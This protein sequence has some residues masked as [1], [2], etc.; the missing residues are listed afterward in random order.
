[1]ATTKA[2]ELSQFSS[3]LILDEANDIATLGIQ[4]GVDQLGVGTIT[5]TTVLDATGTIN[6]NIFSIN[7]P[8]GENPNFIMKGAG[9]QTFRF[10]NTNLTGSTR[11]SWKMADRVDTDWR[12]IMYTDLL[13]NGDESFTIQGKTSGNVFTAYDGK[14]GIGTAAPSTKFNVVANTTYDAV[15]IT[16]AGTGNALVVEDSTNPDSTPTVIDAN[17]RLIVG[18]SSA[19]TNL[20]TTTPQAQVHTNIASSGWS[21]IT[22]FNWSSSNQ[23]AGVNFAKSRSGT[24]GTQTIVQSGDN[25]GSMIFYGDDGTN[26]VPA[27]LITASVD[28]TPGANDMPGRLTFATSSDGTKNPEER[29]RI[30]SGGRVGIGVIPY[31]G[32]KLVIG[33]NATDSATDSVINL[34]AIQPSATVKWNGFAT[35]PSLAAGS[36]TLTALR[37][38]DANFN[39]LGA[40]AS[41]TNQFGFIANSTLTAAS[42]NFGFYSNIPITSGKACW[43]FFAAGTAPNYFGGDVT[44]VGN[45]IVTDP[46]VQQSDIGTGANEIPT[47][48]MLGGMAYQDPAV[49]NIDGGSAILSDVT[50]TNIYQDTDISNVKPSLLLDFANSKQLDPRVTFSRA[51]TA[52]YY[53]GKTVT[54]A[55]EN[56]FT[57]SQ[58][59]SSSNWGKTQTTVFQNV[60]LA[61][62]GTITAAALLD[63]TTNAV[64]YISNAVAVVSSAVAYTYS[65][66][67]KNNGLGFTAVNIFDGNSNVTWFNL[68]NVTVGTNAAGNTSSIV[69]A[70]N[71]WRRISVTRTVTAGNL[72]V[73][74]Y[75]STAD[76]LVTYAGDGASGLYIWGAQL[77]QRSAVSSYTATTTQPITNYIPVLQ[78]APAG[79]PRFE[80]NP[81]TGES[82]GLEIEEQRTNVL[83]VSS[84]FSSGTWNKQRLSVI[85]NTMVAPDGTLTADKLVEDTTENNTHLIV[86]NMT[87]SATTYTYSAYAKAGERTK[88][89]LL[90][91]SD[92]GGSFVDAD[93][94]AGTVGTVQVYSSGFTGISSAITPVGNGVYRVAYTFTAPAALAYVQISLRNNGGATIY[95]GDGYSGLYVWGA[96]LEVG[97]FATSYMTSGSTRA[98]DLTSMTGTDF[99]SWYNPVEG[100]LYAEWQKYGSVNFQTIFSVNDASSAGTNLIQ[101]SH[102]SGAPNNSHRFDVNAAGASQVLTVLASPVALNTW[103]KSVGAYAFNNFASA[104]NGGSAIVDTFGV[105]PVVTQSTIGMSGAGFVQLNGT[106][107]RIAYYP[108]R[109]SNAEL[110]EMTAI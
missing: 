25:I 50:G 23:A 85:S 64:H 70:G 4:V 57:Q 1:M 33:G 65:V 95:T 49:V 12:W 34:Q 30:D 97:G 58:N 17:G 47:N 53:D 80:H 37:H 45:L 35:Y 87:L 93:L 91:T 103:Y 67:V 88:I 2:L 20:D 102:G 75:T 29:M 110:Q 13:E 41:I 3:G 9:E 63:N 61:P 106:I 14:V 90:V 21:A 11:V 74:L 73:N 18:K 71:G 86:Q 94:Q 54:K 36:Y 27:A 77:E 26:F 32:S 48:G 82:L 55:E 69:D 68:T 16:Q 42:N 89:R 31:V 109:L 10:H 62:D 98:A 19:S 22:S 96:Q 24:V 84:D 60:A 7:G 105:V 108:K 79:V 59:F 52:T 107:K 56:L 46:V 104:I 92:A 40:G 78:T 51:S 44:I 39:T 8:G 28:G 15:R 76:G 6:G 81:V 38:Y 72:Y 100:T 99:T 83:S 43:N 101:L 5:P 66:F